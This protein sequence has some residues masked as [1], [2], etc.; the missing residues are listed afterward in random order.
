[1]S[2]S[3]PFTTPALISNLFSPSE[4]IS[5]MVPS[6]KLEIIGAWLSR[7]SNKPP[8]PG[9]CMSVAGPSNKVVSGL[10]ILTFIH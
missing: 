3:C 7:I 1:M 6:A 10:M 9:N 2:F 8:V 4:S 5:R